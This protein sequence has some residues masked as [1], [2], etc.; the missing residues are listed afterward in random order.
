M[1]GLAGSQMT[2]AEEA[3]RRRKATDWRMRLADR[4]RGVGSVTATIGV[5]TLILVAII[6]TL[7]PVP[8][9]WRAVGLVTAAMLWL[10]GGGLY[11]AGWVLQVVLAQLA[12][13]RAEAEEAEERQAA[14]VAQLAAAQ[15]AIEAKLAGMQKD[16]AAL[17]DGAADVLLELVEIRKYQILLSRL[18]AEGAKLNGHHEPAQ[19]PASANGLDQTKYLADMSE[20]VR[21]GEELARRKLDPPQ[22]PN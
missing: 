22:N 11:I 20:A 7:E 1:R 18:G 3:H 2:K 8:D 9:A 21:L 19:P 10:G 16:L 17:R 5:V 13:D 12:D 4:I 6:V 15:S 14:R